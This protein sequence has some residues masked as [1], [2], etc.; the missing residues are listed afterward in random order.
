MARFRIVFEV[1]TMYEMVVQAPDEEALDKWLGG[2]NEYGDD[3]HS[4]VEGDFLSPDDMWLDFE[5]GH[6]AENHKLQPRERARG[7]RVRINKKGE[8]IS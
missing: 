1:P 5:G 8:L 4:F 2:V 3:I 7:M 6:V